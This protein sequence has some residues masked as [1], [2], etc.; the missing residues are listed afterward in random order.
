MQIQLCR[1]CRDNSIGDGEFGDYDDELS[2]ESL[3]L[4]LLEPM[5]PWELEDMLR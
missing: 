2:L 3:S 4:E 5:W 1:H